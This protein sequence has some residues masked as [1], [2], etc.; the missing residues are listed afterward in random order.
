MVATSF[1][2]VFALFLMH[3]VH[4]F[5]GNFFH[6]IVHKT[7]GIS[8]SFW[9]NKKEKKNWFKPIVVDNWE[10]K[11]SNICDK[12]GFSLENL[13]IFYCLKRVKIVSNKWPVDFFI[14]IQRDSFFL[15]YFHFKWC[16]IVESEYMCRQSANKAR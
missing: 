11:N 9:Q 13:F 1:V 10:R 12:N 14:I 16:R 3:F 2:C 8:S 7:I 5:K 4:Y 6:F 15:F